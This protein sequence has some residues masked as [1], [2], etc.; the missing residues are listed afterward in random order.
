MT[1]ITITVLTLAVVL[2]LFFEA[3]AVINR[4]QQRRLM[5]HSI[6]KAFSTSNTNLSITGTSYA[7]L[8]MLSE[9]L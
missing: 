5:A 7:Q 8:S 9:T 1:L 6:H 3:V 2:P 4:P